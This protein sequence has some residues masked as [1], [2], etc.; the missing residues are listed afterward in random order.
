[1]KRR[2]YLKLI[3]ELYERIGRTE[4]YQAPGWS[5]QSEILLYKKTGDFRYME[6]VIRDMRKKLSL[7]G[8]GGIL[9]PEMNVTGFKLPSRIAA[10]SRFLLD[11]EVFSGE[12]KVALNKLIGELLSHSEYERGPMN[13]AL[14][15]M[16]GLNPLREIHGP[17]RED[18]DLDE[19]EV[20]LSR[21]WLRH[22]EPEERAYGYEALTYLYLMEWMETG[23]HEEW[24]ERPA[25][26]KGIE[27]LLF[28]R[29]GNGRCAAFGDWRPWEPCW[30]LYIAV[31]EKAAAV[32]QDG[33]F[34]F[35]AHQ[36]CLSWEEELKTDAEQ[37]HHDMMGL[38]FAH[39]WCDDSVEPVAPP[40]NPGVITRNAGLPERLVL[41]SGWGRDDLFGTLSLSDRDEHGHCDTLAL[42]G[43]QAEG[44]LLDDNGR[45]TYHD[46]CH[47]LLYSADE[48]EDFPVPRYSEAPGR[49]QTIR[50]DF[51]SVRHYGHFQTD[52][53]IPVTSKHPVRNDLPAEFNFDPKKEW[54]LL[55]KWLGIGSYTVRIRE[56]RLVSES[57]TKVISDFDGDRDKWIG[58]TDVESGT[59]VFHF[60]FTGHVPE[61][62]ND[63]YSY[64][65]QFLG[66]HFPGILDLENGPYEALEID[67]VMDGQLP[68][69][70]FH[71]IC[72][73]GREGY[74][75]QWYS[76]ELPHFK[77]DVLFHNDQENCIHSLCRSRGSTRVRRSLER[78]RELYLV[79]N[80]LLWIRDT[81]EYGDSLPHTSG[82]LWQ[83]K[84]VI[85]QGENW[86]C[87]R[88]D[89]KLLIYFLPREGASIHLKR[90]DGA[91]RDVR[92]SRYNPCTYYQKATAHEGGA[93]SF[94]TLLI[95]L[96]EEDDPERIAREIRIAGRGS[97]GANRIHLRDQEIEF[98]SARPQPN[99]TSP[100]EQR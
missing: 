37:A 62:L 19:L 86:L 36:L 21:D 88:E 85:S 53:S 23:G 9:E 77:A 22:C 16:A 15:F 32:Y 54:V 66:R 29:G 98:P 38:A 61:N 5:I 72:L 64:E 80:R 20:T 41:R 4:D 96:N 63:Y 57:E 56:I 82:P 45:E 55:V 11:E 2:H 81:V 39:R 40:E 14:G 79:K 59:G 89:Q 73:G 69:E 100:A 71:L 78:T 93:R 60:D 74:P 7:F 99:H 76:Y 12:E 42:S 70:D 31:F 3:A 47:N 17:H 52:S 44:R 24:Y 83:I 97:C 10:A 91:E 8:K 35:V 46:Y 34:K 43:L 6:G 50:L 95:P 48:P 18:E 94:E 84:Q 92:G 51:N 68:A 90:W 65:P 67:F 58:L 33:R 26:K 49:E 27:N 25:M 75:R 87:S 28:S 13:R 1:M 30:G